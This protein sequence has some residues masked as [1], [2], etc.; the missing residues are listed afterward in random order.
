MESIRAST[1]Q[2]IPGGVRQRTI[3]FRRAAV[4]ALIEKK[5]RL[6]EE[7]RPIDFKLV[8]AAGVEP[9]EWPVESV[10]Y[11]KHE[12]LIPPVAPQT[13]DQVQNRYTAVTD[14]RT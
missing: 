9:K 2:H 8:E 14:A 13:P 7:R 12:T 4:P 6:R 3:L 10:T 11:K 5:G 1:V